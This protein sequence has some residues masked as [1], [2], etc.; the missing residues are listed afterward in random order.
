[1]KVLLC[2]LFFLEIFVYVFG[3]I[4][5]LVDSWFPYQGLKLG[6]QQW[7]CGAITTGLPENKYPLLCFKHN[8]LFTHRLIVIISVFSPGNSRMF[9]DIIIILS[10]SLR[11]SCWGCSSPFLICHPPV[12]YQELTDL[13]LQCL[14]IGPLWIRFKD[15]TLV[16]LRI[17]CLDYDHK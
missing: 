12:S 17:H 10:W 11:L 1:M 14:G 7:K 2:C 4:A 6:P 9:K 8:L 15:T 13:H 16:Q 5:W 3:Q